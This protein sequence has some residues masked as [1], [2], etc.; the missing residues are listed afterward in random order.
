MQ[1]FEDD[2]DRT[3]EGDDDDAV[4]ELHLQLDVLGEGEDDPCK[5][6][7]DG[8]ADLALDRLLGGGRKRQREHGQEEKGGKR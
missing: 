5:A 4:V 3:L 2:I 7:L 8:G 1:P 6:V